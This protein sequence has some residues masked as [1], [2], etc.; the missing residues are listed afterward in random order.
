M[1]VVAVSAHFPL[2]VR[3]SACSV[4][5][6]DSFFYGEGFQGFAELIELFRLL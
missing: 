1:D 4:K 6:F 2:T 3:R 5:I